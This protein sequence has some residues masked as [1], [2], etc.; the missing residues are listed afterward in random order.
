MVRR[1]LLLLPTTTVVQACEQ[2]PLASII[3]REGRNAAAAAAAGEGRTD[4]REKEKLKSRYQELEASSRL[5]AAT[6][7]YSYHTPSL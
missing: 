6:T 4:A 2:E 7:I 1:L 3:A 5:Y